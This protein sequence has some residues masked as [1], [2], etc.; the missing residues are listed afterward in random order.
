MWRTLFSSNRHRTDLIWPKDC[1]WLDWSEKHSAGTRPPLIKDLPETI[2]TLMTRC[3]D[4]E[5]SLRPSMEEVKNTMNDL[6]K[7]NTMYEL[8]LQFVTFSQP[9]S[10]SLVFTI[11]EFSCFYLYKYFP[12]SD[13]PLKLSNQSSGNRSSSSSATS[14]GNDN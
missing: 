3:W 14:T 1:W 13:E 11:A 2:E 4:K 12:G 5:P 7:V 8:T 6:M 10:D 9:N